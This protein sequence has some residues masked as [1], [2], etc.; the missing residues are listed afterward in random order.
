MAGTHTETGPDSQ[1]VAQGAAGRLAEMLAQEPNRFA[2]GKPRDQWTPE[3]A[4]EEE[5]FLR[6]ASG[7]R[8]LSQGERVPSH[9]SSLAGPLPSR[10]EISEHHERVGARNF[11]ERVQIILDQRSR[12]QQQQGKTP[13]QLL[14]EIQRLV[15]SVLPE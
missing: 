12:D 4:A 10:R 13:E 14:D 2:G 15:R 1:E 9:V 3:E 8:G 7:G 6:M 5:A 11:A